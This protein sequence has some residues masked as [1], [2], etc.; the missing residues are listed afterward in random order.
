M[1]FLLLLVTGIVD[2]HFATFI[3]KH[4]PAMTVK[5][6]SANS[7][8]HLLIPPGEGILDPWIVAVCKP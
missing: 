6:F 2:K 3:S 4:A 8:Y 7:K 1:P 5:S